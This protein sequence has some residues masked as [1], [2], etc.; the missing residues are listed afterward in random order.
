MPRKKLTRTQIIKYWKKILDFTYYMTLDKIAY[1]SDS[2]V[3]MSEAKLLSYRKEMFNA[4][5]RTK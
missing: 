4:Q 1:G 2:R 3:A 5:K